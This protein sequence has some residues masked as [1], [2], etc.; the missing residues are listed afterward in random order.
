VVRLFPFVSIYW[1]G[2]IW[3]NESVDWRIQARRQREA[4]FSKELLQLSHSLWLSYT[5]KK[6]LPLSY[7]I[8]LDSGT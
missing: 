1:W 4:G 6:S 8:S 2:G 7:Q 3:R 5:Y